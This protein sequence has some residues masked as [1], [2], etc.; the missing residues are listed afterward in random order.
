VRAVTPLGVRRAREASA[1]RAHL[2]PEPNP[3]LLPREKAQR[4][5]RERY[6]NDN[7]SNAMVINDSQWQEY[8]DD[9]DD[10]DNRYEEE[11]SDGVRTGDGAKESPDLWDSMQEW[12]EDDSNQGSLDRNSGGSHHVRRREIQANIEQRSQTQVRNASSIVD[13][14]KKD[15][16]VKNQFSQQKASTSEK[17]R[18]KE[19]KMGWFY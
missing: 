3:D 8:D 9:D 11:G 7:Q 4:E 17:L 2:R 16:G 1:A 12:H 13:H 14:D 5:Q 19:K 6:R 15:P 10:D 18:K